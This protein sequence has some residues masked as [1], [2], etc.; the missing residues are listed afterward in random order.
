LRYHGG[1]LLID[2][3]VSVIPPLL[4]DLFVAFCLIT[5]YKNHSSPS[6]NP[7]PEKAT[8]MD[9]VVISN[10]E[11]AEVGEV[12]QGPKKLE[13]KLPPEIPWWGK[14][15]L[16]IFVLF[17][18]LLCLVAIILRVALRNQPPR[19]KHAMLAYLST[20]LVISGLLT[21]LAIMVMFSLAPPPA[22]GNSGLS[23][24]DERTQFPKL[25]SISVLSGADV[26]QELK[27][28]VVVISPAAKIWFGRQDVPA[29]SLGA[30]A[31]LDVDS[32]GYLFVTARH[33]VGDLGVSGRLQHAFLAGL[34]GIW[35]TADIVGVHKQLDLAL[36]WMP[37]RSGKAEFVQPLSSPKDG[38]P[39]FVIGHPQGL[40]FS[41]SSGIIAR[42]EGGIIQI[43][44][45]VSPGNSGGPVYDERGNL[46]GI[47]SATTDKSINPN[48]ENLNFAIASDALQSASDWE[49]FAGGQRYFDRLLNMRATLRP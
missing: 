41:L 33:V 32:N 15:T 45:P 30:G 21:S 9:K 2:D 38:E 19:T 26:S 36:L 13:P 11:V 7:G 20:L 5:R 43:S 10:V 40:R 22:I 28:L 3:N 23:E 1:S 42:E 49:F 12:P 46:L 48:A 18:P 27:P 17:L 4:T 47:V 25:P 24:L 16:S 39:I 44:A 29:N 8:F 35:A 6:S 34:T 31:L 14:A 37:R